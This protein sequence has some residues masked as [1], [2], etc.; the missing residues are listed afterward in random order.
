MHVQHIKV[1]LKEKDTN[2]K[3]HKQTYMRNLYF[4]KENI[5]LRKL[6]SNKE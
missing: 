1:L 2:I 3:N 6:Y 4:N 5:I